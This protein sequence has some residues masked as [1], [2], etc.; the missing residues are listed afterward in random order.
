M[1]G[2]IE[3]KKYETPGG[4]ELRIRADQIITIQETNSFSCGTECTIRDALGGTFRVKCSADGV[5]RRMEKST[6]PAE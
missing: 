2:W 4:E 5:Y 6:R 1:N 3:F